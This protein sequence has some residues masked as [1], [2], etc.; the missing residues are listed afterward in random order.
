M[1]HYQPGITQRP[2]WLRDLADGNFRVE[3]WQNGEYA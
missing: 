1:Y 3:D 2:T